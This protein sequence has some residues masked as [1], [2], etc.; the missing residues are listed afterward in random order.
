MS[1]LTVVDAG[2]IEVLERLNGNSTDP[3][4]NGVLVG[5]YTNN[6]TPVQ[7][8]TISSFTEAAWTGY[9]RQAIPS[10]GPATISG[11]LGTTDGAPVNIPNGSGSPQS[12]YGCLLFDATSGNLI[13]ASLFDSAPAVVSTIGLIVQVT[14]QDEDL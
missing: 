8:D 6:H 12:A 11:T 7:A 14:L 4:F 5:L 13:A 2:L 3:V 1:A 9:A 10:W